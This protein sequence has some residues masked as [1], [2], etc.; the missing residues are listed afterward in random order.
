MAPPPPPAPGVPSGPGTPPLDPH[1]LNQLL[2]RDPARAA[3][4]LAAM[5]P[6]MLRA[7]AT[8][9]AP[10]GGGDAAQI[11]REWAALIARVGPLP[12][13]PAPRDGADAPCA[14]VYEPEVLADLLVAHPRLAHALLQALTP[15][16]RVTQ[17]VTYAAWLADHGLPVQ[18]ADVLASWESQEVRRDAA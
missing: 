17:A 8:A 4:I 14:S 3:A 15:S 5:R 18:I 16:Q 2:A 12:A 13:P 11:V 1:A 10:L 9:H 6:A 7:Q